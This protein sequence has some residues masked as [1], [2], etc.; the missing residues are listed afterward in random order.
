[1]SLIQR[2]PLS[3]LTSMAVILNAIRSSALGEVSLSVVH[4]RSILT[5]QQWK[6]LVVDEDS[7]Q[8]ID[9]V[10]REDDILQEKVMSM[11]L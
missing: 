9:N 6:V 3:N 2:A 10:V 7:R 4:P 5:E 11:F 1:M 8:I